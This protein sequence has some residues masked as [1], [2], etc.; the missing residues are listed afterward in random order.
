MTAVLR[1]N[2]NQLG[3]WNASDPTERE[4]WR[5][6]VIEACWRLLEQEPHK[7]IAVVL[8]PDDNVLFEVPRRP[9]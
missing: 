7:R 6:Q 8:D 1:L 4:G 5:A 3:A 2:R 9:R